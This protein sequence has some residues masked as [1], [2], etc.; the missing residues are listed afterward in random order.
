MNQLAIAIA[1]HSSRLRI[2][3]A[4]GLDGDPSLQLTQRSAI[5][6]ALTRFLLSVPDRVHRRRPID[7]RQPHPIMVTARQILQ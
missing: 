5:S 1:C 2:W 6:S 7:G 3:T 4:A